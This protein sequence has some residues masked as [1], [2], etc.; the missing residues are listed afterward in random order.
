M[1]LSSVGHSNRKS[2]EQSMWLGFWGGNFKSKLEVEQKTNKTQKNPFR[3]KKNINEYFSFMWQ[4][5]DLIFL[6]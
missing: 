2:Y 6:I 4:N 3:V 5:K 1:F